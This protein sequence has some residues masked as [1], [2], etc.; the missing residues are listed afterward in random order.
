MPNN[1]ELEELVTV[2]LTNLDRVTGGA[3]SRD[4]WSTE[5]VAQAREDRARYNG[6]MFPTWQRDSFM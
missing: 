3:P 4:N 1:K 2:D 5:S 6:S